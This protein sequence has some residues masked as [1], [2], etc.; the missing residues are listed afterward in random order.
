MRD[1]WELVGAFWNLVF[2]VS[3]FMRI[4]REPIDAKCSDSPFRGQ[5]T[6]GKS[7][8]WKIVLSR[9]R[10]EVWSQDNAWATLSSDSSL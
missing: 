9:W 4:D 10:L 7:L 2:E 6:L 5:V 3:V 1:L 8:G